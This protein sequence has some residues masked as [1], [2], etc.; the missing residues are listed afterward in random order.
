MRNR[1]KPPCSAEAS[2]EPRTISQSLPSPFDPKWN[3]WPIADVAI[4]EALLHA[5]EDGSWGRY[6]GPNVARLEAV[7]A[8]VHGVKHALVCSSGTIAVQIALRSLNAREGSEVILAA[9]D[10]PGN[11]RAIQDAGLF[12]VL[13]DIDP[14]TWCLD[15]NSLS[16]AI[17]EK[18]VAV[19]VSHLHGG[20]AAMQAIEQVAAK[21]GIAVIEDACQATGAKIGG[22]VAGTLGEVGILSFGG[23][24][25]I[26]AGR[27]GAIL[28]DRDDL[29]QRAKI[30]CERGNNAYP[31][32]ELQAAVVLPQLEQLEMR[33]Q[34]R[35]KHLQRLRKR[36][37]AL[38]HRLRPVAWC[39]DQPSFYK[40]AWLCDTAQ[41]AHN[42]TQMAESQGIPLGK[43]FRG[44]F[45]RPESQ[46]RK[47][48][49]LPHSRE[50]AERTILLHHPILLQDEYA[51]D[52]LADWLRQQVGEE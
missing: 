39:S 42:L 27:G 47:V 46:A 25:L 36:L 22:R 16:A 30:Y 20:L 50:A 13:V 31:L 3:D 1:R 33:N 10:F 4:R 18:A 21:H 5:Y 52:W 37:E 51:I 38:A 24:K 23:S 34:L 40:H 48:G 9:Y 11:F 29:L 45:K 49:T 15:A 2:Q 19:I 7:L 26:T 8:E 44:F 6:H 43:G 12:P 32:S 35:C 17:S 28:T 14:E 41:R